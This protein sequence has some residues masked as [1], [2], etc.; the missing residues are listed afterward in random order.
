MK[1]SEK[2]RLITLTRDTAREISSGNSQ[3]KAR[4][5]KASEKYSP[6]NANSYRELSEIV[7]WLMA[8]DAH[9]DAMSLLNALC[10]VDDEYYWMYHALASSFA[11][12]AWLHSTQH[13]AVGARSD[14]ENALQWIRRDPN[15]KA[16]SIEEIRGSLQRV[17][18]WLD[19]A[20]RETGTMTALHVLSHAM[21]VL[22]MYQQI[23]TTGDAAAKS[24]APH[25]FTSGSTP[26]SKSS[27]TVLAPCK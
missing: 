25:D 5:V 15:A 26:V 21:R 9:Q 13:D 8:A 11:T 24:V 7:W 10:E 2:Q 27:D 4:L 19:R 23:A 3:I 16:I 17:D 18:D 6:T 22:V 12:R 1:L 20:D 14:A